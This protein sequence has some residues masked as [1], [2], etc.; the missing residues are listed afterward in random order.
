MTEAPLAGQ[1]AWVTGSSRGLGRVMA[2]H[3]GRLGAD[4]VVHGTTQTSARA[5]GEGESLDQVARDVA[6]RTG[7]RVLAVAADLTRPEAVQS[8]GRP[9]PRRVRPDRHPGQQRG[10]RHRPR[11]GD[12]AGRRAAAEQRR[13]VHR[14]GGSPRGDRPEPPLVHLRLPGGR[15]RDDRAAGGAHRQP[16]ERGG[17]ERAGR[18]RDVRDGQGGR[19]RVHALPRRAAPALQRDG[20]LRGAGRHDDAPL[21]RDGS[22]QVR[23]SW[24]RWARCRA[25]GSRRTS[26]TPS[27]TS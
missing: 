21:R 26:P 20:Q 18:G 17:P 4:L 22:G 10:R 2:E 6:A 27:R 16:R 25:T 15:A 23:A 3:L 14:A 5:F 7:R 8:G 9:D 13:R 12:R 24:S 1:V 11:G 19:A